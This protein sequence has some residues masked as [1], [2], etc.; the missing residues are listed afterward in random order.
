VPE[1]QD[2]RFVERDLSENYDLDTGNLHNGLLMHLFYTI[3]E[4]GKDKLYLA[5]YGQNVIALNERRAQEESD[6]LSGMKD[7][8]RLFA[9]EGKDIYYVPVSGDTIAQLKRRGTIA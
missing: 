7:M 3:L 2:A 4:F 1:V 9:M 5:I 6:I 8:E